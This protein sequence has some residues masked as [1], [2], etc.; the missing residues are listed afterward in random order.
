MNTQPKH[1][2][3]TG[4]LRGSAEIVVMPN[5]ID[6]GDLPNADPATDD[7]RG[8]ASSSETNTETDNTRMFAGA[9]AVAAL[10][11]GL[12]IASYATGM[13][14]SA[15]PALAPRVAAAVPVAVPAVEQQPVVV[16][17]QQAVVPAQAAPPV[18]RTP[19][20]VTKRSAA[21]V[22]RALP[23]TAMPPIILPE[24][25]AVTPEPPTVTPEPL[26]PVQIAPTTTEP[27]LP[28][29]SLPDLPSAPP[30]TPTE[31]PQ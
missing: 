30:V 10:I 31:P 22:V 17:P 18:V 4:D 11:G 29:L 8:H 7:M 19:P 12:G 3:E 16:P 13:W 6:V 25:P 1:D 28:E 21:P 15:P 5:G 20:Q 14:N 9:A 24:P 2:L 27:A 26:V 23:K